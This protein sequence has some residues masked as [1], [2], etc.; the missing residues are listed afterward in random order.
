MTSVF[1]IVIAVAPYLV[2]HI[3]RFGW[4]T[5]SSLF[6]TLNAFAAVGAMS[7][8]D[9][10]DDADNAY[11]LILTYTLVAYCVTAGVLELGIPRREHR[12]PKIV[13]PGTLIG[14]LMVISLVITALY[15]QAVGQSAL[16]AGLR[17]VA[18]GGSQDVA[19]IRLDSYAG[20]TY[21]FPGYVNQFK[22][23]MLPATAVLFTTY[24][25][26]TGRSRILI[27]PVLAFSALALMGT[28]QRTALVLFAAITIVYL[29]TLTGR[30]LSK[31]TVL[32]GSTLLGLL[33]VST[34][35]LGR[36]SAEVSSQSTIGGR[37]G[38]LAGSLAE[39]AFQQDAAGKVVGFRY[40]HS[41]SIDSPGSEWAQAILGLLP[42][43]R[44]STLANEIFAS[45]YG[46]SRGNTPPSLWASIYYNFGTP[47]VIFAPVILASFA[48]F[49]LAKRND[50]LSAP[51]IVT[52]IGIAGTTVVFGFWTTNSPVTL[53]NNGIL[54][55]LF[56]WW[57]GR[58]MT[59]RTEHSAPAPPAEAPVG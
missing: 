34:Y 48:T 40:I 33:L 15:Y 55:Y 22:N 59:R 3:R 12:R 23:A 46:S 7:Y 30:L 5:P 28:G 29:T 14:A 49:L 57:L 18:A 38:V 2:V 42:G 17:N 9:V 31:R 51:N 1:I 36:N 47:G 52:L 20:S 19:G 54:V 6:V 35:A 50:A 10:R 45:I 41:S 58:R 53:L 8:L 44:G 43:N 21:L 11:A 37:V 16:L 32:A 26:A 56:L 25:W 4:F 39:R 13:N 24:W 27:P